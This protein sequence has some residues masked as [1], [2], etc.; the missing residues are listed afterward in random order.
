MGRKQ[1]VLLINFLLFKSL[2]YSQVFQTSASFKSV[3]I[4]KIF[5]ETID[6]TDSKNSYHWVSG[7]FPNTLHEKHMGGFDN[8]LNGM[9]FISDSIK[10]NNFS[11][12]IHPIAIADI[13]VND[14]L[15][16]KDV[17]FGKSIKDT[18]ISDSQLMGLILTL[19]FLKNLDGMNG[20][21]ILKNSQFV[22]ESYT[23]PLPC[24]HYPIYVEF[25]GEEDVTLSID[26]DFAAGLTL[27]EVLPFIK[28][29]A[30][31]ITDFHG[32]HCSAEMNKVILHIHTRNADIETI[33]KF[34][35]QLTATKTKLQILYPD[36]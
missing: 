20:D 30:Q 33:S 3:E 7:I 14:Q 13:Q 10:N 28:S 19:P 22:F 17:V 12:S 24:S 27:D 34:I 15:L 8:V 29:N 21:S 4:E 23:L 18:I 9:I 6:S 31:H 36:D 25:W 26:Y 35:E 1:F 16:F 11:D 5:N 2:I 32:E